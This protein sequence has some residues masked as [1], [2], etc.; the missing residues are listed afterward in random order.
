MRSRFREREETVKADVFS[1]FTV[2]LQQVPR[3]NGPS[4]APCSG[5]MYTFHAAMHMPHRKKRAVGPIM[6]ALSLPCCRQMRI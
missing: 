6:R 2:L 4:N 1:T 5:R 3:L